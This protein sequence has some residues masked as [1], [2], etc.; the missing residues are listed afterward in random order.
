[1][2]TG[3]TNYKTI[4]YNHKNHPAGLPARK[5]PPEE[6]ERSNEQDH[7]LCFETEYPDPDRLFPDRSGIWSFD[8]EY[9]L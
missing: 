5:T 4:G 9:R 8:A 6:S 3:F 7:S 2:K 1:M